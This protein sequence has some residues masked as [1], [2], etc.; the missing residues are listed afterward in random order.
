MKEEMSSERTV[1]LTV[2][3]WVHFHSDNC[4]YFVHPPFLQLGF[5]FY[6]FSKVVASCVDVMCFKVVASCVDVMCCKVVASCVDVM[7]FMV[8]ASCVWM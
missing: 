5:Y 8:V 3:E 7:C 2:R 6:N 4:D 1:H